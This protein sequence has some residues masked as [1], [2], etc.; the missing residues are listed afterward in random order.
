M[1]KANRVLKTK[2]PRP[3]EAE[4]RPS[5]QGA[6]PSGE[7]AVDEQRHAG[8]GIEPQADAGQQAAQ[9]EHGQTGGSGHKDEG[10]AAGEKAKGHQSADAEAGVELAVEDIDDGGAQG[11]KADGDGKGGPAEAVGLADRDDEQAG[12]GIHH[13][14]HY[15]I[16]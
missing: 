10:H 14:Y 11:S 6:L 9:I 2:P 1:R 7:P 4:I 3:L 8:I 5:Q 15:E 16:S 13:A 12:G